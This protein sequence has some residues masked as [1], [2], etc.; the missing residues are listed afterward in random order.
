MTAR[1]ILGDEDG[2]IVVLKHD[3]SKAQVLS[4]INMDNSVYSTPVAC[5]GVLY[6][7]TRTQLFAIE[8]KDGGSGD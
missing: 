1:S 4:E 6:I 2:D 7:A 8:A 3:G 5:K